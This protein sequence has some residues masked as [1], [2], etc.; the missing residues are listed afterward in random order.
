MEKYFKSDLIC[1]CCPLHGFSIHPS[2]P[3]RFVKGHMLSARACLWVCVRWL[4]LYVQLF[5]DKK[6]ADWWSEIVGSPSWNTV[7][8]TFIKKNNDY[9]NGF[10]PIAIQNCSIQ[11][12]FFLIFW[13]VYWIFLLLALIRSYACA[14][15]VLKRNKKP[16]TKTLKINQYD[17]NLV[18][19]FTIT[20]YS[21]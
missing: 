21:H 19:M 18:F 15:F 7:S 3:P 4:Y 16:T 13:A 9:N 10:L 11:W 6:A 2:L 17:K 1:I 5:L 8:T 12:G 14:L 20:Q